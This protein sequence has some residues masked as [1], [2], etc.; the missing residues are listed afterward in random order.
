MWPFSR[1]QALKGFSCS[2]MQFLYTYNKIL[3]KHFWGFAF[4]NLIATQL[5]LRY[6]KLTLF[7]GDLQ[8]FFYTFT[9]T[10]KHSLLQ[11]CHLMAYWVLSSHFFFIDSRTQEVLHKNVFLAMNCPLCSPF[12]LMAIVHE[13]YLQGVHFG[14]SCRPAAYHFPEKWSRRRHP[15][16]VLVLMYSKKFTGS[17]ICP[18]NYW[19]RSP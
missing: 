11:P 12:V 18:L 6:L 16:L 3:K 5:Q 13:E 14:W 2:S 9:L 7:A 19:I 8:R 4:S 1:H 17:W 10:L 15:I